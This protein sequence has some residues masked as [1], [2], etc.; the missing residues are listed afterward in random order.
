MSTSRKSNA[1][2]RRKTKRPRTFRP[3]S[4]LASSVAFDAEM[5]HVHLTDGRLVSVPLSWSPILFRA[6]PE[7]REKVE[8]G[9]GG[10]GL[11]WTELDEE[12]SVAG[13]LAGAAKASP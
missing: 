8:I 6:T 13:L 9:G 10:G 11:H 7:A 2:G 12:L 4:A 3:N 5:M 1:S